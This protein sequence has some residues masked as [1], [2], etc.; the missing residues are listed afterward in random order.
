MRMY[1]AGAG[2]LWVKV[3]GFQSSLD[4]HIQPSQTKQALHHYPRK[5]THQ[6]V[7]FQLV[8]RDLEELRAVQGFIRRHQKY[9]LTSPQ[10]PEVV[11]WWPERGIENWTGIIKKVEGGDK[12]FNP[13]PKVS[14]SVELVDS[15]LS[16]KTWWASA[17]DDFAKFGENV[18]PPSDDWTVPLPSLPDR[19]D[20]PTP[21]GGD[22]GGGG[23]GG[24]F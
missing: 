4:G 12:R 9:A 2:S 18:M 7:N 3:V 23:A 21:G 15:M 24:T 20:R 5:A 19:S 16:R 22:F 1:C 6:S 11:L 8:C 14:F 13:V 10:R 17:A